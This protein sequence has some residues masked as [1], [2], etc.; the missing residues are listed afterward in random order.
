[1]LQW[2]LGYMCLFQLWFSQGICPV[3]EL[4]GD[5][6]FYSYFFKVS[7][8]TVLHSGN[9]NLQSHQQCER[10]P[11]SPQSLQHLSFVE[12][13]MMAILICVRWYLIVVLICISLITSNV[14]HLFMCLVAICM[15]SLEKCL[16]R[17]SAHF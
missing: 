8:H 11:F 3:A 7:L 10:V 13:L 15:S 14:E 2:T 5:M 16:F 4:L 12:F 6:V 1:M 9:L 17:C